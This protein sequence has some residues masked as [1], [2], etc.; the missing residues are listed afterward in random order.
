MAS[1]TQG[2]AP[3]GKGSR[4]LRLLIVAYVAGVV[5]VFVLLRFAGDAWWP[6]SL[7]LFGPRWVWGL[8]LLLLVPLA[9]LKARAMLLPLAVA[10]VLF[11]WPIM[12]LNIAFGSSGGGAKA[13]GVLRVMSF[14]IG[15]PINPSGVEQVLAANDPDVAVFQE[16][17]ERLDEASL[18]SKGYFVE[19]GHGMCIASKLPLKK[20]EMI[21]RSELENRTGAGK[22]MM[23]TLDYEGQ[24]IMLFNLHLET[25]REGLEGLR[26]R[27]LG[28]GSA[29]DANIDQRNRESEKARHHAD[30]TKLPLVLAGDFNLPVE[31]AIFR[32]WW[33]SYSSAFGETGFGYGRT[34][35]TKGFGIRIDHVLYGPA[36]KVESFHVAEGLPGFD[37]RPVVAELRLTGTGS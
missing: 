34:K 27:K 37:H 12:G 3:T 23:Y 29:M 25:I 28:G 17:S 20:S 21:E 7:V 36:W 24:E 8:P 22:V 6:A 4:W 14:N 5:A 33:S 10:A 1:V 31:S 19:L 35:T 15:G 13:A 30:E 26:S 11:A 16:C 32:R 18:K 9:A 2:A